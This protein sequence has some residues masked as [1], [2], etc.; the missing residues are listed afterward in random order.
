MYEPV[1]SVTAVRVRPVSVCVTVIVTPGSAR[2]PPSLTVPL[3]CAV[4]T[5]CAW[6]A[7]DESRRII[8]QRMTT[9]MTR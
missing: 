1:S 4:E 8:E 3:I 7:V 5:D 6:S 2:P 9:L